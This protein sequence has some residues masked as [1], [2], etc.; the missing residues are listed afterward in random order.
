M[1]SHKIWQLPNVEY[2]MIV[3][4]KVRD[5][6]NFLCKALKPGYLEPSASIVNVSSM[7]SLKGSPMSEF[8]AICYEQACWYWIDQSRHP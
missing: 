3:D 4:T 6:F 7:I 5:A 1:G 8:R 2:Y